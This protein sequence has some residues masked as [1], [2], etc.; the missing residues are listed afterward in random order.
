MEKKTYLVVPTKV[1][2]LQVKSA[3]INEI[4]KIGWNMD[5]LKNKPIGEKVEPEPFAS[6]NTL[7]NNGIYLH[8]IVPDAFTKGKVVGDTAINESIEEDRSIIFPNLCDKFKI[9]RVCKNS[10]KG[11]EGEIKLID[12]IGVVKQ[13]EMQEITAVFD[14]DPAYCANYQQCM[15]YL[16][17]YDDLKDL[18]LPENFYGELCYIVVGFYSSD[19]KDL[20]Y[21]YDSE[22]KLSEFLCEF[23]LKLSE[24]D[25]EKKPNRIMWFGE[26]RINIVEGKIQCDCKIPQE[27]K[28]E[29]NFAIGNNA[30]DALA[31]LIAVKLKLS[32]AQREKT[33]RDVLRIL[34]EIESN[35]IYENFDYLTDSEIHTRGFLGVDRGYLLEK[36]SEDMTQ[37]DENILKELN[38]KQEELNRKKAELETIQ[39]EAYLFWQKVAKQSYTVFNPSVVEK[40]AYNGIADAYKEIAETYTKDNDEICGSLENYMS[41]MGGLEEKTKKISEEFWLPKDPCLLIEGERLKLKF[42]HGFD[43]L[44]V[45]NDVDNLSF[46]TCQVLQIDSNKELDK[47]MSEDLSAMEADFS[48]K[49][50]FEWK[51]PWNPLFIDWKVSYKPEEGELNKK[52]ELGEI[53]FKINDTSDH[54]FNSSEII[55][56]SGKSVANPFLTELTSKLLVDFC[57]RINKKQNYLQKKIERIKKSDENLGAYIFKEHNAD[58]DF[59]DQ[60]YK[61]TNELIR[62]LKRWELLAMPLSGFNDQLMGKKP[63]MLQDYQKSKINIEGFDE[64]MSMVY[65]NKSDYLQKENFKHFYVTRQGKAW[66][67][68]IR[69]ID[70]FGRKKEYNADKGEII[71]DFSLYDAMRAGFEDVILVIKKQ[72]KK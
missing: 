45:E 43:S 6:C 59:M 14:G 31:S 8:W 48:S 63:Q 62:K 54:N 60:M 44:E 72:K 3:N 66:L 36:S 5:S 37:N 38:E 47:L 16:G 40:N 68:I 46:N 32:D 18:S 30:M 34:Y 69:I 51:E 13:K 11:I 64:K 41:G 56:L 29:I 25:M 58:L 28:E 61:V 52:W 7:Y 27:D 12:P 24:D 65:K 42:L 57:E 23:D 70:G 2:A 19:A 4:A 26:C 21:S 71:L 50:N 15:D 35:N 17:S 20:L 33:R 22:S 39:E 53:D 9:Y 67:K 49:Y 55:T 10:E 1:Q